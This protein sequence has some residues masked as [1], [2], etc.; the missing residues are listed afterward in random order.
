[1]VRG[2]GHDTGWMECVL[3][4]EIDVTFAVNDGNMLCF[5]LTLV[6]FMMIR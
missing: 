4:R 6:Y 2:E 1:M 5:F 3:I